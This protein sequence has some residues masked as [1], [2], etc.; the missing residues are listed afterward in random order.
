LTISNRLSS[1]LDAN[2]ETTFAGIF[3]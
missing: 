1:L 3:Y 2:P